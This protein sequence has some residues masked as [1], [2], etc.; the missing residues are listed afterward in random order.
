MDEMIDIEGDTPGDPLLELAR[1]LRTPAPPSQRRRPRVFP[2]ARSVAQAAAGTGSDAFN[3]KIIRETASAC[4]PAD[5]PDLPGMVAETLA[6]LQDIGPTNAREAMLA[7]QL[8]ATH[9]AAMDS[10]ALARA[11]SGPLSDAHLGHAARLAHAHAAL[12]DALDRMRRRDR[13]TVVFEYR[14]SP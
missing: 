8:L 3:L 2:I 13:Q 10:F 1:L 5:N 9:A 12:S 11:A 6:G 14:H 4:S 7:A